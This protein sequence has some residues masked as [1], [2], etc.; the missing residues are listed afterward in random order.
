[1]IRKSSAVGEPEDD[2]YDDESQQAEDA[3]IA[4][5]MRKIEEILSKPNKLP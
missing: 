1:V 2:S 4:E 5:Q 3:D